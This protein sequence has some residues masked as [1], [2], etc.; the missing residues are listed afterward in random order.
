MPPTTLTPPPRHVVE[1]VPAEPRL[2][3]CKPWKVTPPSPPRACPFNCRSCSGELQF[4]R[5]N[6]PQ[7]WRQCFPPRLPVGGQCQALRGL[8]VFMQIYQC[9]VTLVKV[10]FGPKTNF[11]HYSF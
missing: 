4:Q 9:D 10:Q 11:S 1:N 8:G 2:A 7:G 5:R 3:R 6:F